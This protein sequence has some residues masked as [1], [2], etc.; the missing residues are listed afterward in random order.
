MDQAKITSA[1][2]VHNRYNPAERKSSQK[3][4]KICHVARVKL[5]ADFD[6]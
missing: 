3:R 1:Q 6:L 5:C 2:D 4:Q